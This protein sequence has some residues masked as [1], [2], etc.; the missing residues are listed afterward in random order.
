MSSHCSSAL[1][2]DP[3]RS[4]AA[5]QIE[6]RIYSERAS[7]VS[8]AVDAAIYSLRRK[9][10]PPGHASII[11]TRRG[12]GYVLEGGA[13]RRFCFAL[14]SRCSSSGAV[15]WFSGRYRLS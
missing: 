13:A 4:S 8:N 2:A 10:T 11:K 14:P 9:L 5:R 7:P 1:P 3:G 12:L 15:L 6:A